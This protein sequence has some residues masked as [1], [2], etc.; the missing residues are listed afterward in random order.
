MPGLFVSEDPNYSPNVFLGDIEQLPFMKKVFDDVRLVHRETKCREKFWAHLTKTC[1][2]ETR[3][4]RWLNGLL[5]NEDEY[6]Q[7][8]LNK[9]TIM[10]EY[11]LPNR[12]ATARSSMRSFLSLRPFLRQL[13]RSSG[14][15]KNFFL[16][17][18]SES[19]ETCMRYVG[20][21]ED[22][23]LAALCVYHIM[24]FVHEFSSMVQDGVIVISEIWHQ[25][26]KFSNSV[27]DMESSTLFT[28]E[29]KA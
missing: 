11:I 26:L 5:D 7:V 24:T 29:R 2:Y 8:K 25:V 4:K 12:F 13:A 15:Y 22:R 18:D 1:D 9:S 3:K 17:R 23:E 20:I 28:A 27:Q 14:F 21:L 10:F 19:A 6:G 16:V